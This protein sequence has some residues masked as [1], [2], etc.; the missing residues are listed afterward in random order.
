MA[1]DLRITFPGAFYH[2]TSRGN[3]RKNVFKSKRDRQTFL[4]YL[5][6]ATRRYDG[7]IH[8]YCMMDNHY[9]LLLQTPSGNLPHIMWHINGAYTT[10]FN[11]NINF[12]IF[13]CFKLGQE[14][15]NSFAIV[16]QKKVDWQVGKKCYFNFFLLNTCPDNN[17]SF[18][19]KTTQFKHF[20]LL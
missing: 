11:V 1:R 5:E 9:H 12:H 8:A 13:L 19:K 17:L 15:I 20:L 14:K 7:R 2:V 6:S 3:E 18:T 4:E 10:Y 16:L